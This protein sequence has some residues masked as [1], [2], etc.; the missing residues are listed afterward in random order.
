MN[1]S[2]FLVYDRISQ[3]DALF[4]LCLFYVQL[5]SLTRYRRRTSHLRV[6]GFH[7]ERRYTR[8][9]KSRLY[10]FPVC[11]LVTYS[12]TDKIIDRSTET[13]QHLLKLFETLSNSYVEN[14]PGLKRMF[15]SKQRFII[16]RDEVQ[17][18]PREWS[19]D[20]MAKQAWFTRSRF[21]VLYNEFF[22]KSPSAD[23]LNIR[24]EQAKKLLETTNMSVA[25]ISSACGY[26]SCKKTDGRP[27]LVLVLALLLCRQPV[28][29]PG[30]VGDANPTHSLR[31]YGRIHCLAS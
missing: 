2:A 13:Q 3:T 21:T 5:L 12:V 27:V 4:S 31:E 11:M 29:G 20:R 18:N 10:P 8:Q 6:C 15:E 9:G 1:L 23:L 14:K 26:H 19:V 22:G 24:T 7:L 28:K 30:P 16:L 25:D 17:K